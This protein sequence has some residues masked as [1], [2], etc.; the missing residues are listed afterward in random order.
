MTLQPLPIFGLDQ[1]GGLQTNKKPVWIADQA[2]QT[3]ENVYI[4]RDR[5]K[6]REGLKFLGRLQ[7]ILTDQSLGTTSA[8]PPNTVTITNIFSTLSIPEP[9][10]ELSPGQLVITV[11]TPDTATF[12]DLG[13]GNFSVTGAGISVGSYV[14]YAT[15]LVVLQFTALTGGATITASVSYFPS[16]PAMGIKQREIGLISDDQTLFFDTKYCYIWNGTSFQEFIPGTTWNGA[17][18]NFFWSTNYRGIEPQDR[19]F[20]VTNFVNTSENPMRYVDSSD[21]AWTDFAPI[22]S[23][24]NLAT[25]I[26]GTIDGSGTT[27][28]GTLLHTPIA[29]S[30][31]ITVAG[32]TF[33]DPTGSGVLTGNPNTNSGTIDYTTGAIVLNFTPTIHFMGTITAITTAVNA[34]VTSPTHDLTTGAQITITGV[35]GTIDSQVNNMN[36]TITVIDNNT[37]SLNATTTGTYGSGGEWILTTASSNV[38]ATYDYGTTFLFQALLLIPYFGRLLALNVWEGTTIGTA[39]NIFNRCRF[40][41]VGN[42]VQTNAWRT[43]IFGRGGFVDAPTNEQITGVT[44]LNNTLIVFFEQTTWQLRYVGEY[45]FPFVFER[46]A[47]DLGSDSTFSPVL[48]NDNI[49]AVGDKG[50]IA[51][52]S[53]SVSRIDLQIPDQIFSFQNANQGVQ[54]IQGIR[55]YQKEIVFWNFPDAF[56]QAAPGVST[57]FP[58]KVMLFNYRNKSWSIFRDN[59]TV[60]GTFPQSTNITWDSLVVFWDSQAVTWDDV[61]SQSLFPLIVSGNQQGFINFYQIQGPQGTALVPANEQPSL[62]ITAIALSGNILTL[63]IINH[64]LAN[65]EI[66]YLSQIQFID[67][68]TFLPVATSLN[69]TLYA[70]NVIDINTI[71]LAMW[72][73]NLQQY[74][75]DFPYTPSLAASIYIGGGLVT[76]FPV[77]IM[78]TKD[79]NPYQAK[80]SQSMLSRIDFLMDTTTEPPGGAIS[81]ITQSNPCIIT[82]PSHGLFTGQGITIYGVQGMRQLN[83]SQIYSVTV[84]DVNT[85]SINVNSS[86]YN[87]YVGDGIWVLIVSGMSVQI[88]KNSSPSVS[89]N[90]LIGNRQLQTTGTAP[91]YRPF[92]SPASQYAWY[93]F[94][95][96]CFGQYFNI[97]MT[98]DD[99]LMNTIYTHSQILTL[100]ALNIWTREAGKIQF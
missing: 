4:W 9:N 31:L 35:I 92:Y 27:F 17:N 21:T 26:V 65:G 20:F 16:L 73:F 29:G 51:A 98:Y 62:S 11:G 93:R 18:F 59:V 43:D 78:Q 64:N 66:I 83:T 23:G 42:P 49:L 15:G 39:V 28:S 71:S 99:D 34:V 40:S 41:A 52:N 63:T 55:D 88:F 24:N 7:R 95:A 48:F 60:F 53:N 91:F 90:V 12:T 25:E 1:G 50:I 82:S 72:A 68:T 36:F 54:R 3:L 70:V 57:I 56:T 2:F 84:I 47:S 96:N 38:V 30:V 79:F 80:G 37:F 100:N 86:L 69:D 6:K 32:I 81:N 46:I 97:L 77:P 45:G 10:P 22:V 89:G 44:F 75:V 61:D 5:A 19:L 58:N 85:F 8:G 33:T 67:S 94:Y 74:Y 14:N 87:N 76:L 13:D